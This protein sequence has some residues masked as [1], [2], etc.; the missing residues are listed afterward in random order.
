MHS[1]LTQ[2]QLNKQKAEARDAEVRQNLKSHCTKIRDGIKKNDSTS[3]IRAIWELF[4]NASDL[5]L[6]GYTEIKITLTNDEFIFAHKGK[7]FTYDTLCSLVKQV[8]SHDKED[9]IKVGQYGTGFL[10]THTFGRYITVIGSMQ[11]S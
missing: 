7:A 3:S 9:D 4:Q 8:S 6:N 10:S 1:I 11:I 5:A 2:E